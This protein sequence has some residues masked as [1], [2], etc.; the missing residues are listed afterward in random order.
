MLTI[1]KGFQFHV[2]SIPLRKV[3]AIGLAQGVDARVAVLVPDLAIG[4][5]MAVVKSWLLTHFSAP[6]VWSLLL[7]W[8]MTMMKTADLTSSR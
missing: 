3:L 8:W 5:A 6:V 4:V 1:E 7:L 2:A